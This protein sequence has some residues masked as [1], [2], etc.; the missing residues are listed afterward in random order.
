MVEFTATAHARH[1][2][3]ARAACAGRLYDAASAR[4]PDPLQPSILRPDF[5]EWRSKDPGAEDDLPYHRLGAHCQAGSPRRPATPAPS[6]DRAPGR[7]PAG[8]QRGARA[9]G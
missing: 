4:L 5:E 8:V 3:C 1:G 7:A 2:A 9:R 6:P